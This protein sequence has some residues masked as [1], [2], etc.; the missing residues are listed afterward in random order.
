MI[1]TKT[2]RGFGYLEFK[3]SYGIECSLQES[4]LASR[5][6]ICMGI[7][8]ADPKIMASR[9]VEGGVGGVKYVLPD[10]ILIN[11]QMHLTQDMAKELIDALQFFVD[12][13]RLPGKALK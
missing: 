12:T 4:S 9:V 1:Y 5:D 13:G 10:D 8:D 11:T 6:C 2:N 7:N 3:D